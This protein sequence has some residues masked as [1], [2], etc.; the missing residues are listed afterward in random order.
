ML[1][2]TSQAEIHSIAQ[3]LAYVEA[4]DKIGHQHIAR[5]SLHWLRNVI[6]VA[7]SIILQKYDRKKLNNS[8]ISQQSKRINKIENSET[9][10]QSESQNMIFMNYNEQKNSDYDSSDDNYVAMS[11]PNNSTQS[12]SKT[13][14]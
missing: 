13:W 9:T 1:E 2:W 6:I 7:F 4:V 5:I 3:Q 12:L 11:E 8:K 10:E 14:Q